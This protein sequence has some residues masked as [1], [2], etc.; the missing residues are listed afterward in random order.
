VVGEPPGGLA[1]SGVPCGGEGKGMNRRTINASELG[2]PKAT[3]ARFLVSCRANLAMVAGQVA[4][5]PLKD[6]DGDTMFREEVSSANASIEG[7]LA[8]LDRYGCQE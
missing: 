7:A 1:L 4:R 3:M 6:A 5:H 2:S 8:L